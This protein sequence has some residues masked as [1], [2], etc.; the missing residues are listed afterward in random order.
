VI[1]ASIEE[2]EA[3]RDRSSGKDNG[4]M[5]SRKGAKNRNQPCSSTFFAAPPGLVPLTGIGLFIRRSSV[6][7][8]GKKQA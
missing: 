8:I 3:T 5:P 7:V 1:P 6:F 4:T 2:F